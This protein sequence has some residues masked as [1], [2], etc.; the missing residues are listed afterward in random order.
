MKKRI[1]FTFLICI[2]TIFSIKTCNSYATEEVN[3]TSNFKDENLK[4]AILE[5]AKE[6]TGEEDK[7]QIYETDI[8]KIVEMPGGTSLRLANK[9]IKDLSGI[10]VFAGKGITWIFL[11]WNELTDLS[12]LSS[13]KDLTKISFSG[14]VVTDLSPLSSLENLRN[15]TAIN[16]NIETLEPIANLSN[17][18]YICLD[19]N[20]LTSIDEISN[21]T[22]LIEISFANNLIELIP[23]LEQLQ[24]LE[25]IN[26]SNNKI[27]SLSGVSNVETLTN[28]EIDNNM[29]TTLD[30]IEN[31]NNL[32]IL[33]CSNNQIVDITPIT[34]LGNLENLN[35]NAN[36]I[37]DI[38]AL[39]NNTNLQFI[40]LD[41][42]NILDFSVLE[43]LNNL[44]KY[45]M[46]NQKILVEIKEKI[47][48]NNVLIPLP[49]LYTNL[50][51]S[52][53]FIYIEGLTTEVEGATD[54]EIDTN[55]SQIKLK[56]EDLENG[57]IIVKVSDTYNTLLRYEIT[58][59]KQAPII[60]GVEN[61]V[62]YANAI[63]ITSEDTD[64][65]TVIL[66][67]DNEQVEYSLG[68]VIDEEGT[69]I[70]EVIDY[71]GNKTTVNF[72]I[73]KEFNENI[74]DY[75]IVDNYIVG[76]ADNTTLEQFSKILNANLEFEVIREEEKITNK[77]IVATGDTLVT[78]L[79]N[80][81]YLIVKG[82]G[83]KDGY[84][85]ITD[86]LFLKR[87]LLKLLT[88]DEAST[89]AMDLNLDD[90]V[91]ITD[92]LLMRRLLIQ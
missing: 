74:E 39:E 44:S 55:N 51:D 33:S 86:L 62:I 68:Q 72:K 17:I 81:Y 79:G 24:Q 19:G 29:L 80:K 66:T 58:L 6:A 7:T 73:K 38:N 78:E 9:G 91:D 56:T 23:N 12:P 52:N 60:K 2:I 71:A 45:T 83:N 16:N 90:V 69:Y 22:N 10:E 18:E 27:K 63:T 40:Y 85:D 50:Y 20:K 47:T 92:L 14:N 89:K 76:I 8:D 30:G 54:Y 37:E 53:S 77:Q 88:F 34:K 41:N 46:Y 48:A 35:L 31:F 75:E 15:I 11:D 84:A 67:K 25:K 26:L 3:I 70:L 32:Q 4:N 21:W 65:E 5:L 1:I 64:I 61:N 28:V 49:E 87:N 43:K 82:D 42:N 36:Q 57:S 13:L 59:D